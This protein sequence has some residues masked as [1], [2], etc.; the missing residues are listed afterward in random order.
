[1]F[2][3]FV[4]VVQSRPT[5]RPHELQHTRLPC[6][7]LS[8]WVYSDSCAL[9]QWC[10]PT[11]S[12]SVTLFSSCPQSFPPSGSFQMS[13]FFTWGGQSYW[14]FS[15]STS[16]SSE[17]SGL[18]S[19]KINWF[20]LLAVQDTHKSLLQHH[21]SKVSI[22]WHSA[23]FLVQLSHLYMSTRKTNALTIRTF[24]GSDVSAF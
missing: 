5:L 6:P 18:I 2:K 7:S 3:G 17:Y 24:V 11:I 10:R 16:S 19:F 12:S 14:S 13:Q 8:P 20:D 1:M 22:F 9:S 4:V 21:S 23:F 15:F